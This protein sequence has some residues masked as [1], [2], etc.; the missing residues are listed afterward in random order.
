MT[1]NCLHP[2]T[3]MATTMVREAGAT[4][5]STVE[6]GGEAILD[7][8]ASPDVAGVSG[9]FFNGQREGRPDPQAADAEARRRLRRLSFEL[10]G[11]ADAARSAT[12]G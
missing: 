2:A 4:P 11:I 9:R 6:E 1:V 7:L 12:R 5:I 8:V 10:V 3:Y